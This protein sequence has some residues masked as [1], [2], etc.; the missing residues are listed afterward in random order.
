MSILGNDA[1]PISLRRA[2]FL[3]ALWAASGVAW[4]VGALGDGFPTELLSFDFFFIAN[5]LFWLGGAAFYHR[6]PDSVRRGREPTPRWWLGLGG[7]VIGA[8]ALFLLLVVV[9]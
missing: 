8:F 7:A 5:G 9:L 4:L 2:D 1:T 3:A 6:R